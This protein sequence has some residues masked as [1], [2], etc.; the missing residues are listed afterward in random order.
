M[1]IQAL[2]R[3][4]DAVVARP[5]TTTVASVAGTIIAVFGVAKIFH[6]DLIP[7]AWADDIAK[8]ERKVEGLN[9]N[10][11]SLQQTILLVQKSQL[12]GDLAA[13]EEELRQNPNSRAAKREVHR[14]KETIKQIDYALFPRAAVTLGDA[15]PT[16]ATTGSSSTA[17][18]TTDN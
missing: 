16:E 4:K 9:S 10:I 7:F 14:I 1:M 18:P 3:A 13:A 5:V 2:N 6:I 8:I 11:Q 12:Q 17:E 15:A